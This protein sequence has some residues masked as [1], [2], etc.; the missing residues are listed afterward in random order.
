MG[1]FEFGIKKK[2]EGIIFEAEL[3]ASRSGV[4]RIEVL[5]AYAREI[6]SE[7]LREE[8]T[9][10]VRKLE[11]GERYSKVYEPYLSPDVTKLIEIAESK[12]LPIAKMIEE[13]VPVKKAVEN[14][15]S[16]LKAQL[17][18]PLIT[19]ALVSLVFSFVLNQF[20][21]ISQ[22]LELS[23]YSTFLMDYYAWVMLVIGVVFAVVL[24]KY[25]N[26]VPFFKKV[27]N[28][29]KAIIGLSLSK[30]AYQMGLSSADL[31]PMLK[32]YYQAQGK[33]S[34]D[35]SGVVK[36]LYP[37][38]SELDRA[39]IL[40]A[41]KYGKIEE[42]LNELASEKFKNVEN[43]RKVINDGVDNL[44]KVLIAIPIFPPLVVYLD[45][46]SQ[47]TSNVK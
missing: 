1:V 22:S 23:F 12:G 21:Q 5:K 44:T 28:E 42:K 14:L 34:L 25:P 2:V 7:R 4:D 9:K 15:E 39:Q 16:S 43:L 10:I 18:V 31:V 41:V 33:Y 8:I 13:Y 6:K 11:K 40:I 30:T 26:K 38:L 19:F 27:Y 29:L 32:S 20:K 3:S 46:L 24:W 17:K 47:V 35:V 37:Y 36:L 45:L